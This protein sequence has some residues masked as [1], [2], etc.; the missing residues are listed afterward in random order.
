MTESTRPI[1]VKPDFGRNN[2]EGLGFALRASHNAPRKKSDTRQL[3]EQ[4]PVE[5]LIL[6]TGAYLFNNKRG[7]LE[8][9]W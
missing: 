7:H 1:A 6:S 8:Q 2:S 9:D 5:K 3:G 4:K